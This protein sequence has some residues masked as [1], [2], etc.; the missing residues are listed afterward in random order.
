M[1][2][3]CPSCADEVSYSEACTCGC[4]QCIYC[5]ADAVNEKSFDETADG[6][7]EEFDPERDLAE[8]EDGFDIEF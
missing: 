6:P 8:E 2:F 4:E 1:A 3:L 5:H 7:Q